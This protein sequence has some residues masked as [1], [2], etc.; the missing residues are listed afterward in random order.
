MRMLVSLIMHK[1]FATDK[2]PCNCIMD[3]TVIL[4]IFL[5]DL[6]LKMFTNWYLI[7]LNADSVMNSSTDCMLQFIIS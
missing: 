5:I 7:L 2:I 4:C 1:S 3:A 6:P